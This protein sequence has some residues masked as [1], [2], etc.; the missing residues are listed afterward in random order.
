VIVVPAVLWLVVG[1]FL[2]IQGVLLLTEYMELSRQQPSRSS[3]PAQQ[4]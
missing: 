3:Q 4:S 2:I 1:L